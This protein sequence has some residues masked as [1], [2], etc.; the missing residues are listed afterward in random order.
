MRE[1]AFLSIL[2]VSILLERSAHFSL[3]PGWVDV[4][5]LVDNAVS[6][7][8]VKSLLSLTVVLL[9]LGHSGNTVLHLSKLVDKFW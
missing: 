7:V 1:L 4:L 6:W 9:L 3:V 2:A 8:V 5:G